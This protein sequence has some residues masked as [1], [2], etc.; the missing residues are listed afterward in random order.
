MIRLM[1]R[2]LLD[3]D[4]AGDLDVSFSDFRNVD[5]I[6]S[7]LSE[8]HR[9]R[10]NLRNEPIGIFVDIPTAL[11]IEAEY[12]RIAGK[13]E[14][15]QAAINE[16]IDRAD[17]EALAALAAGRISPENNEPIVSG[18]DGVAEFRRLYEEGTAR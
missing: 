15:L 9:L 1:P 17:D 6:R 18:P 4:I 3:L 8:R 10:V 2:R 13:F 16:A 7:R 5:F 12:A 11:E 14:A